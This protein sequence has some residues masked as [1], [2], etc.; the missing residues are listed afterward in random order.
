MLANGK[1]HVTEQELRNALPAEKAEFLLR[2]LKPYPGVA[3]AYDFKSFVAEVY[4]PT[5]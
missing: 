4:Q 5:H 3:G 1:D 2:T